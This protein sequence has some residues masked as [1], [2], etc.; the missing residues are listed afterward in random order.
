MGSSNWCHRKHSRR[1]WARYPKDEGTTS[2][3]DK[4]AQRPYQHSGSASSRPVTFAKST[5]PST[6]RPGYELSAT[7]NWSPQPA[8]TKAYS[9]TC[10]QDNI[11]TCWSVK[12]LKR[13]TQRIKD[14]EGQTP[15]GSHSHHLHR[16]VFKVGTKWSHR[17]S[18]ICTPQTSISKMV[19]CP[20]SMRL[21]RRESRSPHEKLHLTQ[22]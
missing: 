2:Q 3:T 7:R 22:I 21:S 5:G 8:V 1:I 4:F 10:F 19:Q 15:M 16:A 17:A 20:H 12:R 11:S 6:I 13:Q 9:S 14:W 18:S